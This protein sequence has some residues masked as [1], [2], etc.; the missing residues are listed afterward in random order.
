MVPATYCTSPPI[1]VRIALPRTHLATSFTAIGRAHW[2]LSNAINLLTV[3]ADKPF[4]ATNWV[5]KSCSSSAWALHRSIEE[6]LK[7][8]HKS[9]RSGVQTWWTSR[10][11]A[12]E[13]FTL[14][15]GPSDVI[16]NN[17]VC[18]GS[19]TCSSSDVSSAYLDGWSGC[20]YD[21]KTSSTVPT[22]GFDS[23]ID[24]LYATP[25]FLVKSCSA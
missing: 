2:H 23:S 5:H 6:L 17:R 15:C 8:V 24:G 4:G 14:D 10:S 12:L 9:P 16:K 22:P 21:C 3:K 18:V 19:Y 7:A 25:A 13:S 1:T 20:C 11:I